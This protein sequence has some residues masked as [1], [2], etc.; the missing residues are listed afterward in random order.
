MGRLALAEPTTPAYTPSATTVAILP[1]Q[2]SAPMRHPDKDSPEHG[3]QALEGQTA[4]TQLFAA[5]GFK[6]A[7]QAAVTTAVH[8]SG[9][10]MAAPSSW[11]AATFAK[12]GRATHADLIVFFV[13][14]DTHQGFRHGLLAP[15]QRE[16]EAKTKLWLIDVRSGAP[17][18]DGAT[19]AGKARQGMLQG[20][21]LRGGN[22]PFVL[23]AIDDA[24][25]QSLSNFLTQYPLASK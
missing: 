19:A 21:G 22:S 14:T 13:I 23:K 24:A 17:T 4:L 18:I 2:N 16:G 11:N 5:H 8:V 15:S 7:D 20:F 1:V 25:E 9:I 12:L 10:D 3:K 6:I